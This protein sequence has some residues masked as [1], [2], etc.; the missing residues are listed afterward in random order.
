M[1]GY[2]RE[3]E[4][5]AAI[6]REASELVRGYHGKRLTV[7]IKGDDEPVTEADHAAN[8]LIVAR[9]EAAFPEDVI[10]SATSSGATPAS[11]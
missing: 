4:T 6:A 1:S 11:S 9:L 3:V 2:E 8:A 7:E 10:L 5:A